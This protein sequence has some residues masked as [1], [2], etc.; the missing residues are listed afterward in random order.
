M[1]RI[2]NAD[3]VLVLLRSHLERAQRGSRKR[4][5]ARKAK[6]GPLQ[7]VQQMAQTESLSQADIARALIAGLLSEEF[8]P[9]FAVEPRFQDMVED[10][11]RVI[12]ADENARALLRR[13]IAQ[14]AAT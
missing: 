12:E 9:S 13:A 14:L 5:E 7:R 2:T 10:V 8:G 11:R 3:Q 1:T 6:S 4:T